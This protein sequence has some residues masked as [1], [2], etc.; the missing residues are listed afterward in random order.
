MSGDLVAYAIKQM[1]HSPFFMQKNLI[2]KLD[3]PAF[4][5]PLNMSFI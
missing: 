4:K 5:L 2:K 1:T 3:Y